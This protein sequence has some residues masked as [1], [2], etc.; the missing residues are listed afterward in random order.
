MRPAESASDAPIE[1]P[2]SAPRQKTE[3]QKP[4]VVSFA[5][6][7][8]GTPRSARIT[9]AAVFMFA[10]EKPF[11]N[12]ESTATPAAQ[13][14]GAV[15][16]PSIVTTVSAVGNSK[17]SASASIEMATELLRVTRVVMPGWASGARSCS[18]DC[19]NSLKSLSVVER[20][21]GMKGSPRPKELGKAGVLQLRIQRINR[22]R[23]MLRRRVRLWRRGVPRQAARPRA[24]SR[25]HT[26][27]TGQVLE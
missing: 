7:V 15:S 22:H 6:S 14:S 10:D 4:H 12:D 26:T 23:R 9:S 16:P 21:R 25:Q 3:T 2:T 20:R 24:S 17:G 8:L 18:G 11:W 5:A 27:Q 1:Q 19:W 13:T